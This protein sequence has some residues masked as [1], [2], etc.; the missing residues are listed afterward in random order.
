LTATTSPPT[1]FAMQTPGQ[2][3]YQ[4]FIS[5]PI[6]FSDV[7][8]APNGDRRMFQPISSTLIFGDADAVLVDPR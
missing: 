8:K 3:S 5:D 1:V 6:P 7:E 2:L 4:V